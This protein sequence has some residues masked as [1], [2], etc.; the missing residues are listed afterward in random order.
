LRKPPISF[1]WFLLALLAIGAATGYLIDDLGL[2]AFFFFVASIDGKPAWK[3]WFDPQRGAGG[4]AP[5]RERRYLSSEPCRTSD[6]ANGLNPLL[7]PRSWRLEL[8]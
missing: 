7:R 5:W 1:V 6:S 2:A 4:R 3:F 8:R